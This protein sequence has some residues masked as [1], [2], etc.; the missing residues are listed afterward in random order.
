M[1]VEQTPDPLERAT[2]ALRDET[3]TG[4]VEVSQ[5]VM[6][7]VRTLVTPASAVISFT[8]DGRAERGARGSVVRV[9]G[10][11]LAPRLR[12]AVDTPD[13]AAD[14]VDIEVDDDRCTAI[15]IALVCRYGLDLQAEGRAARTAAAA[16]VR[17]LL[18]HDPDFDP[19]RDIAIDVVDVVDGDPHTD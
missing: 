16:V 12:D 6:D 7:R 18:G 5:S 11:I 13:R 10:R 2:I 8:D 19:E 14:S 17:E 3:E 9:S 4:W 15:R 1:A